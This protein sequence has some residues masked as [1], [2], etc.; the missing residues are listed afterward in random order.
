MVI[1]MVVNEDQLANHFAKAKGIAFYNEQYELISVSEN[2]AAE[3]SCCGGK[4]AAL[5]LLKEMNTK[6]ILVRNIGQRMLA[7]LLDAGIRV[8]QSSTGGDA[9]S[10][11]IHRD[12]HCSELTAAEQGRISPKHADGH[13]CQGH[14]GDGDG[15]CSHDH[16]NGN[17]K[18][19]CNTN[20]K[21]HNSG[22]RCC[23]TNNHE[24]EHDNS[25]LAMGKVT[26]IS[27]VRGN[28]SR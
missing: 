25:K 13:K 2:P 23:G 9:V 22:H 1:A 7:R 8:Y 11:L 18:G 27:A 17:E 4:K 28:H 16:G 20:T 6:Q 19:C 21:S 3:G 24:H 5:T 10:L 14:S 26:G 15:G 12:I